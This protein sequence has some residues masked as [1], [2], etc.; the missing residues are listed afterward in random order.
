MFRIAHPGQSGWFGLSLLI[1]LAG[2]RDTSVAASGQC[3]VL[4]RPGRF[5]GL[6]RQFSSCHPAALR[7]ND[8]R[9]RRTAFVSRRLK[10]SPTATKHRN[11]NAEAD[12]TPSPTPCRPRVD[13]NSDEQGNGPSA[14]AHV[15]ADTDDWN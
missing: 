1:T 2:Y 14:A 6:R 11:A 3:R 9:L 4:R 13:D 7:G 10:P 15:Y 8:Q 5:D 12:S